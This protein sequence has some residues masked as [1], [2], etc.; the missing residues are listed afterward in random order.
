M[1]EQGPLIVH[2]CGYGGG[3]GAFQSMAI[4]YGVVMANALADEIKRMWRDRHPAT[5]QLWVDVEDA[6]RSAILH[7][8]TAYTAGKITYL[9]YSGFLWCQLPSGTRLCYARP[10][11]EDAPMPWSTKEIPDIRPCIHFWGVNTMTHHWTKLR[12]YGGSLVENACQA[13]AR[14]IM[15]EGMLNLDAAGYRI[16]LTV[17]D[18]VICEEPTGHGDLAEVLECMTRPATWFAGYPVAAKGWRGV[19]MRKG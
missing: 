19:R 6:A 4:N 1:T 10:S 3:V 12:T 16:V 5:T 14:D 18:E 8:R 13:L 11:I 2:N 9:S 7:P 17:H 15:A